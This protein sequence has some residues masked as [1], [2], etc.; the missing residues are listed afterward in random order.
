MQLSALLSFACPL[1]FL[2]C[3]GSGEP[4]CIELASEAEAEVHCAVANEDSSLLQ[5]TTHKGPD[6]DPERFQKQKQEMMTEVAEEVT[7]EE[8]A[9]TPMLQ[10]ALAS[11]KK[12]SAKGTDFSVGLGKAF[13]SDHY[14]NAMSEHIQGVQRL[15]GTPYMAFTGQGSSWS[16]FFIAKLASTDPITGDQ[17]K[18]AVNIEKEYRHAGGLSIWNNILVV[19]AEMKCPVSNWCG[20]KSRVYFYDVSKPRSPVKLDILIERPKTSAGA[21]ALTQMA[22]DRFLVIVGGWDSA[23]LDFYVSNAETLTSGSPKFKQ[24]DSWNR[25]ELLAKAGQSSS[26]GSYQNL[27]LIRQQDGQLFLVGTWRKSGMFVASQDIADLFK[28]SLKKN[29]VTITKVA[30]QDFK[31]G[32]TDFQAG[33]GAYVASEDALQIYGINWVQTNKHIPMSEFSR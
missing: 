25:K 21:V 8:P 31:G 18:T 19:G 26:F 23:V 27:N 14:V 1:L 13:P 29:K 4:N 24:I 32:S 9:V 28:V 12:L 7:T 16:Q 22:D 6:A 3:L 33:A 2:C 20:E 11:F 10:D 30:S 17:V 15:Y 5:A